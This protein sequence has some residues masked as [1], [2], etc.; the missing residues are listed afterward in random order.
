MFFE[1]YQKLIEKIKLRIARLREK[2]CRRN[3]RLHKKIQTHQDEINMF[4]ND[5]EKWK[6]RTRNQ[7]NEFIKANGIIHKYY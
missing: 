6:E 2:N 4:R 1:K 3:N 5:A 7:L